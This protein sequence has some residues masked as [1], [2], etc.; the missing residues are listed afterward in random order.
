MTLLYGI[1]TPDSTTLNLHY[2]LHCSCTTV[3]RNHIAMKLF[4]L[5]INC[6]LS[7]EII[8]ISLPLRQGTYANLELKYLYLHVLSY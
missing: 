7:G 1:H 4:N 8:S 2:V 5:G 6:K 3:T